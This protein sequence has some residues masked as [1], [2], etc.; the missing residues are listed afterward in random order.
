MKTSATHPPV[1][2]NLFLFVLALFL[3]FI[4]LA[5]SDKYAKT[6]CH[7]AGIDES[8]CRLIRKKINCGLKG[9]PQEEFTLE[10]YRVHTA[11]I[12][13]WETQISPKRQEL[14]SPP[15]RPLAT[16][17]RTSSYSKI[18]DYNGL[19][20]RGI[21]TNV[22]ELDQNGHCYQ[23]YYAKSRGEAEQLR[24]PTFHFR[25]SLL[26]SLLSRLVFSAS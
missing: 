1:T 8:M 22:V 4:S 20:Q 5:M 3:R 10:Y 24:M 6:F 17:V 21:T 14:F 15:E 9:F 18:Y 23:R 7:L 13:V 11:W 25:P 12:T 16:R 19:E 2:A 26:L